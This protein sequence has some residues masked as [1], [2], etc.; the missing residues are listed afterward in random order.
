MKPLIAKMK[1]SRAKE[2]RTVQC[3][4]ERRQQLLEYICDKR[5][6]SYANLMA[7]FGI[8]RSTLYRDLMILQCSY[9]I[10]TTQGN[11]GGVHVVDGYYI[12]RKYLKPKQ[13]A[14][15]EQLSAT[16]SGEDAKTMQ[17]ILKTFAL[18]IPKKD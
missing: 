15:L 14:L 12:G 9:P 13:K 5:H 7:E 10:Y 4:T 8:A 3:A 1:A 2:V 16:L 6:E 18:E 11:G 17:E